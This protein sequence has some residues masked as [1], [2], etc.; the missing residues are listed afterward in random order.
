VVWLALVRFV[1]VA[2]AGRMN[3]AA[4]WRATVPAGRAMALVLWLCGSCCMH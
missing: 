4:R 3:D 2:C 1:R